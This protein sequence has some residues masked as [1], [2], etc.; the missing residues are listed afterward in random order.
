MRSNSYAIRSRTRLRYSVALADVSSACHCSATSMLRARSGPTVAD[1]EA[2]EVQVVEGRRPERGAA[3]RAQ[4]QARTQIDRKAELAGADVAVD[5]IAVLASVGLHLER[6]ER[7]GVAEH[8][9]VRVPAQGAAEDRRLDALLEAL[10][11]GHELLIRERRPGALPR[12]LAASGFEAARVAVRRSPVRR[13]AWRVGRSSS[14]AS[15]ARRGSRASRPACRSGCEDRRSGPDRTSAAG[16]RHRRIGS[17]DG[18]ATTAAPTRWPGAK[19]TPPRACRSVRRKP[20]RSGLKRPKVSSGFTAEMP[21]LASRPSDDRIVEHAARTA[22][23]RIE[24]ARVQARRARPA[25]VRRGAPLPRRVMIWTTPPTASAPYRLE[26]GPRRI[27]MRSICDSAMPAKS[28]WPSVAEPI[29]TPSTSTSMPL[30]LTPRSRTDA[31]WP[32]PPLRDSWM[33]PSRRSRSSTESALEAADALGVDDDDVADDPVERCRLAVAGDDDRRESERWCLR[34]GRRDRSDEREDE[35]RRRGDARRCLCAKHR[36]PTM[37]HERS[38]GERPAPGSPRSQRRS[39]ARTRAAPRW[40]VSGLT[41]LL[42][43]PSQRPASS[44]ACAQE[45]KPLE[46]TSSAVPLRGQRRF[47]SGR[48]RPSPSASRL[49]VPTEHRH[50]HQRRGL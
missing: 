40:P 20:S 28:T 29:R 17:A 26:A 30:A 2:R 13:T 7:T 50:G 4:G 22:E 47:G 16:I 1:A 34:R 9:R 37:S 3:D 6:T 24:S 39:A 27:S 21:R 23:R 31:D 5:R 44:V 25:A 32:G 43:R 49:T 10:D 38:N 48:T 14:T 46:A 41:E 19:V 18:L 42:L 45:L 12:Q 35:K 8:Q 33:P 11:G 15:S 36:V